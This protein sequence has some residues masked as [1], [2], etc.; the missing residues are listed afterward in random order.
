MTCVPF[1]PTRTF[2]GG[3]AMFDPGAGVQVTGPLTVAAPGA[4]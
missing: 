3:P 4:M 1:V 2:T